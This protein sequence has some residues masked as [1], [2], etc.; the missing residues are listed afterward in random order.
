M[1]IFLFK[2]QGNV[3]L[4]VLLTA[5]VFSVAILDNFPDFCFK[6]RN[7]ICVIGIHVENIGKYFMS[8]EL[9]NDA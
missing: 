1:K 3:R 5:S 9:F 4:Q 2:T 6:L 7:L 8:M